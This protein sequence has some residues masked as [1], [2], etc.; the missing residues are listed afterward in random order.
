MKILL[1]F[2]LC[3]L[4]AFADAATVTFTMTNSLG[5]ADTNSIKIIPIAAYINADGSVQPRGVPFLI[6]PNSSGFVATNLPYGNYQ[7]TNKFLVANY[8]TPGG[9]GSWAGIIFAVP[10]SAGTYSLG[11]LAI[12]G[13]NVFNYNGAAFT[14]TYSNIIAALGYVPLSALQSTNL[15]LQLAQTNIYVPGTN[16]VFT[17]NNGAISVSGTGGGG[18]GGGQP[19]SLNLTNWSQLQ[20]N[21]LGQ[22]LT[23]VP[24]GATNSLLSTNSLPAL[25]NGFIRNISVTDTNT[26]L[27]TNALPALTNGFA[28]ISITNNFATTQY[29][30]NQTASTNWALTSLIYTNGIN[31]SNNAARQA[32][33]STN[34]LASGA[35][36]AVGNAAVGNTNTMTV[37]GATNAASAVMIDTG[38]NQKIFYDPNI[39]SPLGGWG[40]SQRNAGVPNPTVNLDFIIDEGLGV[41]VTNQMV[42]DPNAKTYTFGGGAAKLIANAASLTNGV[43]LTNGLETVNDF[44]NQLS[45]TNWALVALIY[46]NSIN[47]TNFTVK[48]GATNQVQASNILG[49][50]VATLSGDL[51]GGTNYQG[52]NIIGTIPALVLTNTAIQYQIVTNTLAIQAQILTN[53]IILSNSVV[54][55][56]NS[57]V[58]L[59]NIVAY[60]RSQINL[61]TNYLMTSTA[62]TGN[63]QG[64]N[65]WNGSFVRGVPIYTN[66]NGVTMITND[67]AGC[68]IVQSGSVNVYGSSSGY[69]NGPWTNINGSLPVPTT[70]YAQFSQF[71]DPNNAAY[72]AYLVTNNMGLPL[73]AFTSSN[74][75]ASKIT[76]T[77]IAASFATNAVSNLN[78]V[79]TNQLLYNPQLSN[80]VSFYLSSLSSSTTAGNGGVLI[81]GDTYVYPGYSTK[82]YGSV[83]IGWDAAG[84]Y[85]EQYDTQIGGKGINLTQ[86]SSYSTV[87]GGQTNQIGLV[88]GVGRFY[89]TIIGGLSNNIDADFD[90]AI[91]NKCLVTNNFTFMWSDGSSGVFNSLTNNQ[92]LVSSANGVLI[93]TNKTIATLTVNGNASASMGFVVVSNSWNLN[94][95][96]S[97]V[98]NFATIMNVSSNGIPMNIYMS[99]GVPFY[100]YSTARQ[101]P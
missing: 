17:T 73:M 76:A 65:I 66:I 51:S 50:V 91:G 75:W 70:W 97:N 42:I 90:F 32:Y 82:Y 6:Y 88:Y 1:T 43:L 7:A 5:Q 48:F 64:T 68:R 2:I 89:S 81:S 45:G 63:V 13:Y 25:T 41:F 11:Q 8:A 23:G 9:Y 26:F 4:A 33:Y 56:T 22:Y 101:T 53:T 47:G 78:G 19:P 10:Q 86:N 77:N 3:L 98:P 21:V 44:T 100:Y 37:Y 29:V 57:T 34:N 20:T 58:A 87:V 72:Q 54:S 38:S 27:T 67:A 46:S 85:G 80:A 55:V 40:L 95:I 83:G 59:S 14:A 99:N 39:L 92:F 30:T 49:T 62:G 60:D 93:N 31:G 18:S 35:F 15:V 28:S 69:P 94:A 24:V 52:T 74:Y 79:S 71:P 84:V 36:T 12:P 61:N 96:T 16:I